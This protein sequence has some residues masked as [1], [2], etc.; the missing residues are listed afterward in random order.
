M[1]KQLN[2]FLKSMKCQDNQMQTCPAL[3]PMW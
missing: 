2:K 3:N 1:Y